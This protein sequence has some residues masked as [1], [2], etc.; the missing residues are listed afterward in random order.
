MDPAT[1]FCPN[2][3]CPA[4]GQTGEGNIRIHSR[5]DQRFLCTAG[6]K[7]FS[8]TKGTAWSRLR[9]AAKTVSLVVTL[10]AHGC[11]VQAIVAAFRLDERTVADWWARAG[12]Q[13]QAVQE[14]LVEQSHDLGHVQADEIRVKMQG[15]MVWMALAMM[16]RTRLWL[17][18]EVSAP[19]AMPLIRRLIVRGRRCAAPRP[20]LFCTDGLCSSIRAIRETFRAPVR[21]GA[22]GRPRLRPWRNVCL[23]P[24]VKRYA[25]R[26]VVDIE[27]RIVNGTPA[28]V[29]PLRRR[30][31]G[32][33]VIN[34]AYIE[35]RP[36]GR[37][38]TLV[39]G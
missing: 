12:Q 3:E 1:V 26:R 11:P 25:Q 16:V 20:L 31:Q 13:G 8:A 34:T 6:H 22:P 27:R 2:L 7:T 9:T 21:K 28:R 17:A 15:G 39:S 10:L 14:S 23:A 24:V 30:A 5:K 29:E 18:G 4:R 37:K 32:V 38:E 19:R 35:V 33:G 36:V